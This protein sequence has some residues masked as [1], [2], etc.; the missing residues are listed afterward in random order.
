MWKLLVGM[1]ALAGCVASPGAP[2]EGTAPPPAAE[3]AGLG[4]LQIVECGGKC[5][6]STECVQA[7]VASGSEA[8]RTAVNTLLA[9]NAAGTSQCEAELEACRGQSAVAAAQPAQPAQPAAATEVLAAGQPHTTA[10]LVPW[11]DGQWIGSNHQFTFHDGD[12]VRRAGAIA[13]AYKKPGETSFEHDCV[14]TLNEEGTVTQQGDFLIMVFD[15]S[16]TNHCGAKTANAGLTV[17]YQ[18]E[19]V[20]NPYDQDPGLQLRLRDVD[21]TRGDMFCLDSMTRR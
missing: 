20:D 11:M 2:V 13:M 4:C 5:G 3:A 7:C 14:S 9:C 8:G 19:W 16:D 6:E 1:V 21:C 18:I 12:R 17:R 15:A 10:N